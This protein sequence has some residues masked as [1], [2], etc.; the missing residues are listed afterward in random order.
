[1]KRFIDYRM[2]RFIC[3]LREP[4]WLC[5]APGPDQSARALIGAAFKER[6]AQPEA[7]RAMLFHDGEWWTDS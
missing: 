3:Q 5:L 2:K 7:G 1:M 6:L 4:D